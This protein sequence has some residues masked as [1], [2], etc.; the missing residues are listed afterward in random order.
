MSGVPSLLRGPREPLVAAEATPK[1]CLFTVYRMSG[2]PS[3]FRGPTAKGGP[4]EEL[5][6]PESVLPTS[7]HAGLVTQE[8]PRRAVL[9]FLDLMSGVPSFF[10]EGTF[11]GVVVEVD[12][13]VCLTV[14]TNPLFILN[15]LSGVPFLLTGT[16][17]SLLCSLILMSG[18]PSLLVPLLQKILRFSL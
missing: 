12:S 11:T 2:V 3:F 6:R 14:P 15:R 1:R 9:L 4:L 5:A 13:D 10:T 7:E 16:E 8:E 17:N 18:E